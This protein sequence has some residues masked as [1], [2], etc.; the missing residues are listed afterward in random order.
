MDLLRFFGISGENPDFIVG[1]SY[2]M[3]QRLM[4]MVS[5]DALR[6]T[7]RGL[8]LG[9]NTVF[10]KPYFQNRLN[11]VKYSMINYDLLSLQ[12][13]KVFPNIKKLIIF[14]ADLNEREI[15]QML[16][17]WKR[18]L[19]T[20]CIAMVRIKFRWT[21]V[22]I[23][24]NNLRALEHLSLFIVGGVDWNATVLEQLKTF[25]FAYHDYYFRYDCTISERLLKA[26]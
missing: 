18:T 15:I 12:L 10:I 4:R 21:E 23:E 1:I 8:Y 11:P 17:G 19:T 20:L 6:T 2:S 22:L 13:P 16:F 26:K 3:H 5:F 25:Y 9:K 24:I 14:D 7:T